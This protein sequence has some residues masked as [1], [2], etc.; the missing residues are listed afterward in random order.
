MNDMRNIYFI[1]SVTFVLL[2]GCKPTPKMFTIGV[3]QC[4][5]DAWRQKMNQELETERILH[6]DLKLHFR[7]A[8]ANSELQCL[9]I[10]SFI[11]EGVDLLIICPNEANEVEP[12]IVRAYYQGIPIVLS[13]RNI[14]GTEYTAFVGGDNKQVGYNIARWLKTLSEPNG[15]KQV[16]VLEI[17]GL[18]GA[19]P[20]VLRHQGMMEALNGHPNIS[21]VVSAS[22]GWNTDIAEVIVDSLLFT[23]PEVNAIVAQNDLMALGAS[24]ACRRHG[25][26]LPIIGVDGL[27]GPGGGIEAVQNGVI[28]MTATYPSRGDVVLNRAAQILHGE[29]YPRNTII[30]SVLVGPEEAEPLQL[31]AEELLSR[32]AAINA[33]QRDIH[34]LTRDLEAQQL[35]HTMILVLMAVV[36]LSA[37]LLWRFLIYRDRVHREREEHER[38]VRRQQ[39]QL[40]NMTMQLKQTQDIVSGEERFVEALKQEIERHLDNPEL[41]VDLLSRRIGMSRT[42]LYR[43]TKQVMGMSPIDLIHHIRLYKAQEL[44]RKSDMTVQQVGYSVGFSTPGYFAKKYRAEFGHSPGEEQKM[45]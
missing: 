6:P 32:V 1:L 38:M 40:D 44:L 9:Q 41:D 16:R 35:L 17:M 39:E 36:V 14:R 43:K 23:H 22:A 26:T 11:A 20:T 5:D 42:V 28:S 21:I 8:N 29:N 30:K 24:R 31:L 45:Q 19:T 10:D 4:S 25:L 12:A 33:L 3:S 13:D 7:Q 37:V 27:T 18:P 15:G 34:T 2:V